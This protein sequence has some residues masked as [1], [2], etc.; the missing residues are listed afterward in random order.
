[1]TLVTTHIWQDTISDMLPVEYIALHFINHHKD[2]FSINGD[3]HIR[4]EK[5]TDTLR[6]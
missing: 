4:Q 3:E 5:E 1:M 2:L 6:H